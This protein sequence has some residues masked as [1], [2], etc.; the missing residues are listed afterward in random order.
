[1]EVLLQVPDDIVE[2]LRARSG[3]LS[4]RA[5][6][7]L[8]ADAYRDGSITSAEVQR[9]LGFESRMETDAFLKREG[10]YLRYTEE[11]LQRDIETLRGLSSR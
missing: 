7:S 8:A 6:E 9:M 2:R 10:A 1:M 3:D 11:D 4:R 5:L